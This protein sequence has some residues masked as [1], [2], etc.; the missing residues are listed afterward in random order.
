[1]LGA[2]GNTTRRLPRQMISEYLQLSFPNLW[3][4]SDAKSHGQ[5]PIIQ[6]VV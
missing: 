2:L 5:K 4:I 3:T 6:A 1:M